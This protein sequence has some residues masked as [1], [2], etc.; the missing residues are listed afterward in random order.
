MRP[1]KRVCLALVAVCLAACAGRGRYAPSAQDK[2]S[3]P[4]I[5]PDA[6]RVLPLASNKD[7]TRFSVDG[8]PVGTASAGGELKVLVNEQPHTVVA[9]T[10]GYQ[11][12]E[13]FIQP[14]YD[15]SLVSFNFIYKDATGTG[16]AIAASD[17]PEESAPPPAKKPVKKTN[18]AP[19]ENPAPRPHGLRVALVIGNSSYQTLGTLTNPKRDAAEVAKRL[20]AAGFNLLRPLRPNQDV[21]ADL[22]L[23]E[24]RE[25]D[26]ALEQAAQQAE[27]VLLYYA[28]H[29]L[30]LDG[31][32]YLVPVNVPQIN[33]ENLKTEE[34]R[35]TLESQL[36]SLDELI[37]GLDEHTQ[38]AVT[39]FDAC[40]EIPALKSSRSV[41]GGGSDNTQYRGLSRPQSQ[42]KH[43]LLAFSAGFGEL[44]A[45]GAQ[46]SPYTQAFMDEF[47]QNARQKM[48]E[49]F[50]HIQ[51]RVTGATG[52]TP[53]FITQGSVPTDIYLK[54]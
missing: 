36:M 17:E 46:H 4:S 34:G 18:P 33:M 41:F 16:T 26:R 48:T 7:G 52:Q 8:K 42:G 54:P 9:E 12:K 38:L 32:P 31:L 51:A 29:G 28:G 24:M 11:R 5:S 21:Q 10:P 15:G 49:F 43:R 25:A 35:H 22:S 30:Q 44:A 3:Y 53:E 47:D 13:T 19:L 6:S 40:R 50:M 1:A 2:L 14:P 39:V 23:E 45:D 37:K 20:K 27:I